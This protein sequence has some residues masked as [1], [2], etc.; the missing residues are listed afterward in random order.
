MMIDFNEIFSNSFVLIVLDVK[1]KVG[2][3]DKILNSTLYFIKNA[4]TL[5]EIIV[6]VISTFISHQLV[7]F[8]ESE[9]L[10]SRSK[11]LVNLLKF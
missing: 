5:E 11:D 4:H 8:I 7:L 9:R 3:S 10:L 2:I 1:E 6:F